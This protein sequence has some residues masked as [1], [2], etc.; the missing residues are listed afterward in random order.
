MDVFLETFPDF[1]DIVSSCIC[2]ILEILFRRALVLPT[3]NYFARNAFEQASHIV[4][5]FLLEYNHVLAFPSSENGNSRRRTISSVVPLGLM[6]L[7]TSRKFWRWALTSSD[8]F[9]QNGLAWTM[10]TSPI[11]SSKP[12]LS[13]WLMFNPVGIW[14]L[15]GAEN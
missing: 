15:D 13:A 4:K 5:A 2:C 12:S 7:L 3:E 1:W 11:F 8:A 9:P 10:F 14:L 6:V